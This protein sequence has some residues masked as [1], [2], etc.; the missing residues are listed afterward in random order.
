[1]TIAFHLHTSAP[2]IKRNHTTPSGGVAITGIPQTMVSLLI[3][4]TDSSSFAS[5]WARRSTGR[6]DQLLQDLQQQSDDPVKLPS[7][8]CVISMIWWNMDTLA[9]E[10]DIHYIGLERVRNS[11]NSLI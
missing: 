1:M 2:L 6:Q 8:T 9:N 11:F 3:L 5:S 7:N 4:L 10:Y